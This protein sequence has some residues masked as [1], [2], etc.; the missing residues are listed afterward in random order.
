[1]ALPVK[2]TASVRQTAQRGALVIT[3][4]NSGQQKY[5][6]ELFFVAYLTNVGVLCLG[7][8]CLYGPF[9]LLV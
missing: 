4:G 9:R 3:F 6:G 7:K 8:E 2:Q 5:A 1:M